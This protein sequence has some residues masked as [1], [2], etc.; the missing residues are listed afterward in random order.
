MIIRR[1]HTANFTTIGNVLFDDER[2]K[3]DELGILTWLLARPENWEVRRP[4]LRKRFKVGRDALRRIVTNLVR[5]GWAT[6]CRKRLG[7]GTFYT[8]YEIRDECGPEL[9]DDE[10]KAIFSLDSSEDGFSDGVE[11]SADEPEECPDQGGLV[12]MECGLPAVQGGLPATADPP[13][14]IYKTLT[15]TES[16]KSER[17]LA[18]AREKHALQLAEFKRRWP[19]AASDDQTRI[20][21]EWFKLELDESEPALAGIVPFLEK[22]KRDK[23]T[24]VPAAW[25]YL[26]EKRWTLLDHA[27][28]PSHPPAVYPSDSTEAKAVAALHEIAGRSSAFWKIFRRPDGSVSFPKPMTPQFLALAQAPPPEDW[29]SLDRNGAGA[30]EAMLREFF[31][32]AVV[33]THFAEGSRAPWPFP[34]STTGKIYQATAPPL[35]ELSDAEAADF[36]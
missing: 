17:E 9:T 11:G 23:R 18:R 21:E 1:R 2:L 26:R 8:V 10:V 15:N 16:T 3:L 14:S 27:A 6:A 33:R 35:P 5:Y 36:R 29:V 19:T 22:L 7:N 31:D 34:P 28:S 12:A 32:Q 25:K 24:T 13:W 4:Q 20:A 30:W